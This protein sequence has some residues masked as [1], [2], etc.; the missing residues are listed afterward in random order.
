MGRHPH[1]VGDVR[2]K[3]KN[4][5]G[6]A[7]DSGKVRPGSQGRDSEA[8]ALLGS[9]GR[10]LRNVGTSRPQAWRDGDLQVADSR[11][12][13][14]IWVA[15]LDIFLTVPLFYFIVEASLTHKKAWS[16]P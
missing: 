6:K 2:K 3:S 5:L 16:H 10:G 11:G 13:A 4:L 9:E 7:G 12:R 1:N 14:S 8:A 15:H